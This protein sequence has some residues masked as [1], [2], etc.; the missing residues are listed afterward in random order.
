MINPCIAVR[1]FA[2]PLLCRYA[3][4]AVAELEERAVGCATV[5]EL[6]TIYVADGAAVTALLLRAGGESYV[7]GYDVVLEL[8]RGLP[9][10]P[11]HRGQ[12]GPP[13]RSWLSILTLVRQRLIARPS[14]SAWQDG[15]AARP[16]AD[17]LGQYQEDAHR[18]RY[19]WC[20]DDDREWPDD[21]AKLRIVAHSDVHGRGRSP[22]LLFFGHECPRS[23]RRRSSRF[24]ATFRDRGQSR[25]QRDRS[26]ALHGMHALVFTQCPTWWLCYASVYTMPMAT[27]SALP[28]YSTLCVA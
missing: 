2:L 3:E 8:H 15:V 7:A 24:E 20:A 1:R 21:R 25:S 22:F 4:E 9:S 23:T 11:V 12:D 27:T 17:Q 5:D 18:G 13:R 19:C 14:T 16:R 26:R 10:P 28:G 6:R